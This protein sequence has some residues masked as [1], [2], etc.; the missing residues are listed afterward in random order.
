MNRGPGAGGV[1]RRNYDSL[2]SLLQDGL[3][4]A[5]GMGMKNALAGLWWGGG[6]GVIGIPYEPTDRETI[7]REFGLFLN[8][9]RGCYVTAEDVGTKPEDMAYVFSRTRFTTCIPPRFGG[10]GNP[11]PATARGVYRGIEAVFRFLE[12]PL[13]PDRTVAVQGLGEV[14][15]R[16][17]RMLHQTGVRLKVYDPEQAKMDEILALDSRHSASTEEEI[18]TEEVDLVSPCALGAVLTP[19]IIPAMRC[20]AICGA[21]NNQLQLEERDAAHLH[22]RRI[23]YVPDFVVNRMGIVN[24]ADE[25]YGQLDPDPVIERHLHWEWKHAIG[26]L[27]LDLLKRS[28]QTGEPPLTEAAKRAKVQMKKPHPLWPGR[29]AQLARAAW[30]DLAGLS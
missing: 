4:L 18:L 16:L 30:N 26:P 27:V 28:E 3:R 9:L 5:I 22:R 20:K 14:G 15:S 7:Y 6:K 1:R 25:Q 21:A 17:A 12:L 24:C 2:E 13:G 23:H 10:S 8:T 11:S 19:D 29:A